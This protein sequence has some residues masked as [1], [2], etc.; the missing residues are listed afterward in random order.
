MVQRAVKQRNGLGQIDDV[1]IVA[2]PVD[3]RRHLG[4]PAM[5]LMSEMN[6]RLKQLTHGNIGQCHDYLSP[7]PVVPPRR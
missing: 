6:T 4:I 7:S 5:L 2:D 1:D 3:E